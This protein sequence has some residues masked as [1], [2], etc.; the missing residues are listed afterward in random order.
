M[1]PWD[2]CLS[3][4]Q[5]GPYIAFGAIGAGIG[6]GIDALIRKQTTIF[7]TPAGTRLFAVPMIGRQGAGLRVSLK[8]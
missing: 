4:D 2:V 5:V 8:F 7:Q 6:L 3:S 1:E